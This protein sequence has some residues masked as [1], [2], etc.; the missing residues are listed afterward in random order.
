MSAPEEPA[1]DAIAALRAAVKNL[2]AVLM[3]LENGKGN[4]NGGRN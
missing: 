4:G 3:A 1:T 2:S